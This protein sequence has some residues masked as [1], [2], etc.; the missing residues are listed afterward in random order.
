[1]RK[2]TV[3]IPVPTLNNKVTRGIVAAPLT[4]VAKAKALKNNDYTDPNSFAFDVESTDET[5]VPAHSKGKHGSAQAH[6]HFHPI[7]A[8]SN[9]VGD[10]KFNRL[11]AKQLK[12]DEKFLAK[13]ATDEFWTAIWDAHMSVLSFDVEDQSAEAHAASMEWLNVTLQFG[14][15]VAARSNDKD[16]LKFTMQ[17]CNRCQE[18]QKARRTPEQEEIIEILDSLISRGD[19][20]FVVTD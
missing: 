19:T 20:V 3:T 1:M 9:K 14:Q 13:V 4:V 8:V 5:E 17:L 16:W 6:G 11:V 2:L 12:A 15:R 7:N 10:V 18:E